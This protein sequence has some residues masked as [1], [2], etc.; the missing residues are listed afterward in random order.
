[1]NK[2]FAVRDVKGDSF[3]PV[4]T[5]ETRGIAL[6][7][8]ADACSDPKSDFARYPEDYMLYEIGEYDRSTATVKSYPVPQ[9]VV[10]AQAVAEQ[11][12]MARQSPA[13]T[14]KEVV[15]DVVS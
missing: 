3:G 5:L 14:V 4:I 2:L 13:S 12:R 6:R 1:M 11:L 8:F 7:S 10:T 9:L 15:A